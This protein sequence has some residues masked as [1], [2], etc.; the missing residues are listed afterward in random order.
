MGRKEK[1]KLEINLLELIPKRMIEYEVDDENMVT[2]KAPRFKNR[3]LKKWLQPR[4]KTPF[5]KVKLDEI[6]SSVWL[7]CDGQRNVKD[8]A[9]ILR[10]KFQE[11]IEPCY[12]RLGTF[13]QQLER[14]R[15]ISYLNLEECRRKQVE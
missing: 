5:L 2:L 7:L 11:K 9:G 6:G 4:V 1:K 14:T 3:L 10:E 8:M 15:F 12:D 13:F